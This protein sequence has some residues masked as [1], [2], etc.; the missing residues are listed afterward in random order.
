MGKF[1]F[2]SSHP[3]LGGNFKPMR[4][5]GRAPFLEIE[6]ELPADFTGVF[7]LNSSCPQF[8][9]KFEA[10]PL[11]CWRWQSPRLLFSRRQCGRLC[12]PLGT[13]REL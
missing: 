12:H 8:P 9:P 7:Y 6:G 3:Y 2:D 13:H 11:V 5:E 4:F 10:I 1:Q